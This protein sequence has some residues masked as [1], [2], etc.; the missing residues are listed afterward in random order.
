[1][2]KFIEPPKRVV[3]GRRNDNSLHETVQAIRDLP[4]DKAYQ[5][6]LA[7]STARHLAMYAGLF[8]DKKFSVY[9]VEGRVYIE[10]ID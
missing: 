3:K 6:T 4:Q 7:L 2:A 10:R 8:L 1:M 9:E 5:T